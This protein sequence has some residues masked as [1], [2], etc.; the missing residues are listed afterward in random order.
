MSGA[1]RPYLREALLAARRHLGEWNRIGYAADAGSLCRQAWLYRLPVGFHPPTLQCAAYSVGRLF[2]F[3]HPDNPFCNS[4]QVL[5]ALRAA[6]AFTRSLQHRDG[7]FP[8]WYPSQRSFCATS[9][10][11]AYHAMLLP[12]LGSDWTEEHAGWLFRAGRWIARNLREESSNQMAAAACALHFLSLWEKGREFDSGKTRATELLLKGQH[13]EGWFPEYGGADPGYQSL[14][15]DFLVRIRSRTPSEELL[16]RIRRGMEF[17][18]ATVLPDGTVPSACS[19]RGTNFLTPFAIEF[20]AGS[21]AEVALLRRKLLRG[22]ATGAIPAPSTVDA[23][24]ASH[25]LLPSYVDAAIIE[26]EK[27]DA[28]DEENRVAEASGKRLVFP[29]AGILCYPSPAVS[30]VLSVRRGG[31]LQGS[32][33]E[34]APIPFYDTGYFIRAAGRWTISSCRSESSR[35]EIGDRDVETG[36][37]MTTDGRGG[38][39]PTR[40]TKP[41]RTLR[42]AVLLCGSIAGRLGMATRWERY[43]K[44]RAFREFAASPLQFRRTVKITDSEILIEDEILNP[45]GLRV[46]AFLAAALPLLSAQPSSQFF[47]VSD[48]GWRFRLS[49]ADSTRIARSLS[50]RRAVSIEKRIV[51]KHGRWTPSWTS[52][53]MLLELAEP[54]PDSEDPSALRIPV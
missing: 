11:A 15:L 37:L 34:D 10:L 35:A 22:V 29:E 18:S 45:S 46:D 38:T 16:T 24:C 41:F 28:G 13:E 48:L 23:R 6:V 51:L 39:I 3:R 7:S 54:Y 47:S 5:S 36:L 19:M 20:M 30:V 8:E 53:G 52:S 12:E 44:R 14:T 26:A 40:F 27:G 25:L 42:P 4:G 31:C 9:Y 21:S 33:G 49:A 43:M 50:T 17:L 2:L 1:A 32:L